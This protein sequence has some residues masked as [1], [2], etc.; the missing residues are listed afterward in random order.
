MQKAAQWVIVKLRFCN[1]ICAAED[2]HKVNT[3]SMTTSDVTAVTF[4]RKSSTTSQVYI[5][6]PTT[7]PLVASSS[8]SIHRHHRYCYYHSHLILATVVSYVAG[9]LYPA[10]HWPL[11]SVIMQ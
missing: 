1:E 9:V 2:P 11:T 10:V 6:R 7:R 8:S 4:R 5:T 3:K